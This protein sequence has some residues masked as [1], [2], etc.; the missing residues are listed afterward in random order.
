MESTINELF[1]DGLFSSVCFADENPARIEST[2]IKKEGDKIVEVS[3]VSEFKLSRI[4]VSKNGNI[5]LNIRKAAKHEFFKT[6]RF[7]SDA[8]EIRYFNRGWRGFFSKRNPA[9]LA[10][11][12]KGFDWLIAPNAIA[13]ELEQ[14]PGYEPM[15]GHGDIR[16]KG[17]IGS[18]L[19]FKSEDAEGIFL[20][21][22]D[23]V[24]PVFK[25]S[26]SD[27]P[28]DSKMSMLEMLIEKKGPLKKIWVH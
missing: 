10:E 16:L 19:I 11:K 5:S 8:E 3:T 1:G 6:L 4:R 24:I 25:R 28:S 13:D 21:M 23:S 20:G 27:D 22:K 14:V 2:E 17:R 26:M 7:M 15:M 12:A 9:K 18:T